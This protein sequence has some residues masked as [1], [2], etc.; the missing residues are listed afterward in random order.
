VDIRKLGREIVDLSKSNNWLQIGANLGIV[1]GLLLV[2]IQLK[3][4]SDL[5]KIQLLYD[6]SDRAIQLEALL[7]GEDGAKV[8]AKSIEDPEHLTLADQ[9]IMEALLWSYT[10]QLRSVRRLAELGLLDNTDWRLRVQTEAGFFYGS[11]YGTAWWKNFSGDS[12][13]LPKDLVDAVDEQLSQYST[14]YTVEYIGGALK[15]LNQPIH[16]TD[17]TPQ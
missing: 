8:W 4:T 2:G 3:Q 10:E 16:K 6:E 14:N 13:A 17:A 1:V 9:R 12:E 15:L 7:V 11:R 5:L